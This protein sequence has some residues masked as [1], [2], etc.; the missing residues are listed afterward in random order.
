MPSVQLLEAVGVTAELCGRTFSKP[1]AS[2]FAEDLSSYPEAEVLRALS[3]CRKEVRGVLTTA[4]VISRID[5]GRPGV[6]EAWASIPHDELQSIVWTT[7]VAEAYGHCAAL[8]A[9][10]DKVGARMAFKEV[11][12]K[13]IGEARELSKPVQWVASLGGDL[14]SR[15]RVLLAAVEEGKLT[16]ELAYEACPQLPPPKR[17]ELPPPAG[18]ERKEAR[19]RRE[20]AEVADRMRAGKQHSTDGLAWAR[21]LR[22]KEKGGLPLTEGQRQAWRRALE[23]AAPTQ[24]VG[25]F[26]NP[27]P[28]EALPPGMRKGAR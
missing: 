11:Y 16:P 13:L 2:V 10:G 14:E 26:F 23:H 27:I 5:D 1:A 22:A 25:G 12:T 17:A 6:E 19:F 7:E 24:V 21:A 20:L 8:I 15:K 9:S 28:D 4:D 3:R 18:W